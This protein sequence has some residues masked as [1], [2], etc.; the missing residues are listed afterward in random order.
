[1]PRLPVIPSPLSVR[2]EISGAQVTVF[3]AGRADNVGGDELKTVLNRVALRRPKRVVFDLTGLETLW[4][5]VLGE[6]VGCAR[7]V[8]RSGGVAQITGASGFVRNVLITCRMDQVF[9][10]LSDADTFSASD[11]PSN[12]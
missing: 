10:G 12:N 7:A 3:L 1:M 11:S 8:K 2:S 4:S 9:E 6:M 5:L